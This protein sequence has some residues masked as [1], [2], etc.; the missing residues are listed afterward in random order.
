MDRSVHDSAAAPPRRGLLRRLTTRRL[1]AMIAALAVPVLAAPAALAATAVVTKNP[2]GLTAVGP[3]NSAHGFP[4]WY[5][6]SKGTRLELCL[7]HTNPLCGFLPGDVPNE[8]APISF[9][10]NFPEEAFYMLAGS[11]LT[12]AAGAG[13]ATLTLG[14]EAAFANT[15]TDGDQITFA[16]QRIVVRDFPPNTTLHFKHPYGAIDVDTDETGAGR[17]TEDI[18][19]AVG[20][21]RT[22]L[23]GNLGPFLSWG[24]DA[25]AGYIGNPDVEHT[26]TGSPFDFN[27]FSVSYV[28]GNAPGGP[29]ETVETDLFSLQGKLQTNKG[30]QAD[31]A[32][33]NGEF[34]DV[35]VTSEADSGDIEVVGDGTVI[36]TTPMLTDTGSKRFYARVKVNGTPPAKVTVRNIGDDPVSTSVV[37]VTRPSGITITEASFDG[38]SLR[39]KATSATG[40]PL[41]V[42]GYNV[43]VGQDGAVIPTVAPPMTVKVTS[44]TGSAT[45]PVTVSGGT[46]SPPGLPPITSPAPDPGPICDPAPCAEG[47]GVPAGATPQAKA[48]ATPT[49]ALRGATFTLDGGQSTNS[50]TYEWSQ[51]SGPAVTFSD[52]KI[53]KP[54]ATV[55]FA[56]ATSDSAPRNEPTG[57]AV[58]RLT[59]TNN[60]ANPSSTQVTIDVPRDTVTVGS[61]RHRTGSE[62][63]VDGTATIAG[64][65]GVLAPATVVVLYTRPDATAPW[66]KIGT[67]PVDTT[68]AWSVRVRPGPTRLQTQY[69]VQSSRGGTATGALATR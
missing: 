16:R 52:P 12:S 67:S 64:N 60:G 2:G 9:P 43:P 23:K 45:A 41:T 27:K 69:L 30:V 3:V 5:E 49:S 65:T 29:A 14:L 34:L 57:P 1:A 56:A 6:D 37:D 15:V 40:E 58:I 59:T 18:S 68:G 66:V 62:L 55:A 33:L 10:D 50:T 11:Q 35:F 44:P 24:A 51:V 8:T 54:T 36:T 63:R 17:I 22:A 46:E 61:A 19:P 26:V 21:F 39:V 28:V 20:N 42:N 13:R 47:G 4:A 38:A 53:A 48:V 7:D 25:P 32:V 31:A